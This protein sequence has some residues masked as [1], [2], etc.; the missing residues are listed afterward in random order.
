MYR[1]TAYGLQSLENSLQSLA[2]SQHFV[3]VETQF[4]CI[5]YKMYNQ[6]TFLHAKEK[7]LLLPG[8]IWA[9][10]SIKGQLTPCQRGWG[11]P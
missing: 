8:W 2:F 3:L 6:T 4:Q 5:V 9:Q 10:Q 1:C 11:A 7:K